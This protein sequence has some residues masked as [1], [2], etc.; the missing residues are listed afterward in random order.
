LKVVICSN[1]GDGLSGLRYETTMF[2]LLAEQKEKASGGFMLHIS[3]TVNEKVDR[4]KDQ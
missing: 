2:F 1:T 4:W 3:E